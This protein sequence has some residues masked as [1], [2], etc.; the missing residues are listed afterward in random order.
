MAGH[1]YYDYKSMMKN[2]RMYHKKGAI[3]QVWEADVKEGHLD[4]ENEHKIT[5]VVE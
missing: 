5:V 3:V 2:L 4:F 1:D